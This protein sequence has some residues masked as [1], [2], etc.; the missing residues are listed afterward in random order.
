MPKSPAKTT[1][2][3][4][5][6]GR[7]KGAKL[8]SPHQTSTHPMGNRAKN[9]LFNLL[10]PYLAGATVLD[11]YAGTGALGIEALSRGARNV[12]FVEKSPR[13]AQI[14]ATN[15]AQILKQA[16]KSD[17]YRAKIPNQTSDF[18]ANST[19]ISSQTWYL[20]PKDAIFRGSTRDFAQNPANSA[21]FSLVIADPPYD[22]FD[23]DELLI[24]T[25]TLQ[26]GG[27]F[28]LSYPSQLATPDF[29]G[30]NLLTARHYAG[31]ALALY[32]KN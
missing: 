2:L 10:Q 25:S 8:L 6:A 21:R 11:A 31:A 19:P 12:V 16:Q 3:Y 18:D 30:L 20:P 32:Q 22:G 23:P 5:I 7:Y 15:Y 14:L 1:D 28:A 27:I 24:L 9:A 26:P 29:R 17:Y 4:V 13:V